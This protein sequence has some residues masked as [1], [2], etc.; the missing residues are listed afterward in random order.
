MMSLCPDPLTSLTVEAVGSRFLSS[1][2]SNI[3]L[4]TMKIIALVSL[5]ASAS[6]FAPAVSNV[7]STSALS[8]IPVKDEIG[9]LPPIGFFE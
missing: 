7:K 9:V 8:A 4:S 5:I 1:T 6:A 2:I 3:S